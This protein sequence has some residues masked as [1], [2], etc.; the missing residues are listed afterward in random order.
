MLSADTGE[1]RQPRGVA[2]TI[3]TMDGNLRRSET[4]FEQM[5]KL[6][7]KAMAGDLK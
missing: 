4:G 5:D 2:L 3:G 6:S 7:V 1:I